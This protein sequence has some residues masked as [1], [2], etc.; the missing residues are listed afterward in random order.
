MLIV[1]SVEYVKGTI[2]PVV[3]PAL[4]VPLPAPDG[5]LTFVYVLSVGLAMLVY[6]GMIRIPNQL[7][8]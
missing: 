7:K 4:I 1:W 5:L 2:S 6:V 8:V 3:M